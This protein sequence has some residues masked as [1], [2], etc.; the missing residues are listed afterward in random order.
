MLFETKTYY[1][2]NFDINILNANDGSLEILLWSIYIGITL[3][4]LLSILYRVYTG[5]FIHAVVEAGALD[6]EHAVS[7][8]ELNFR[9]KWYIKRLLRPEDTLGRIFM[10][11]GGDA[12][13]TKHPEKID[14]ASAR[15]YLP[16]D[17]RIGAETRFVV[18]KRPVRTFILA[19][20]V[21]FAVFFAATVFL[22]ELLQMLDNLI[23]QLSPAEL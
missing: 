3:G 5:S 15:F 20:V 16:E 18:E 10:R 12:G 21:L 9:G 8:A 6:E 2:K 11:I 17:R 1:Y 23:T 22:P 4:V 14:F 13:D 7:L 19:A